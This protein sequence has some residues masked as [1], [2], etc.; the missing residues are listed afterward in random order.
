LNVYFGGTL[1][2]DLGSAHREDLSLPRDRQYDPVHEVRLASGGELHSLL[3]RSTIRVNSLHGQG[4]DVL[5]EG[6]TVEGVAT[7]GLV[8]AA[9]VTGA[10][11]FQ[12]GVQWHPEWHV[13]SDEVSQI[14][15][16]RFGIAC[17]GYNSSR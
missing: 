4:V 15:F 5:A 6:L 10:P 3:R 7:D 12:L 1:H 13:D 8:E 11:T 2:Q 16:R 9:G 17:Q 14:L